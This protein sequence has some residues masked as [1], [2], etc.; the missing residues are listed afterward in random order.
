MLKGLL[1]FTSNSIHKHQQEQRKKNLNI[2]L[3]RLLEQHLCTINLA[4]MPGP[5]CLFYFECKRRGEN[6]NKNEMENK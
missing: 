3:V 2:I 6:K 4:L 1:S 5:C